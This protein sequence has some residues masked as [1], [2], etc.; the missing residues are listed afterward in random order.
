MPIKLIPSDGPFMALSLIDTSDIS[1][2]WLD[3]S[4]TPD[5]PHPARLLD[6]YLPE[7]GDGPFP[8]LVCIHG[9]AFWGGAK[10]DMQVAAYFDGLERGYAV[11]SVEQRLC[12]AQPGGTYSKEGLFPN[13]VNDF[14]AAIRFLRTHA[15]EYKLDPTRFVTAGGSAGGYHAIMAALTAN[16]PIMYDDSLGFAD[17]DDSVQA[18]IDWFGVGDL[19]VQSK[20][21][22][23]TPMKLP[24]G[25]EFKMDNY[26]DIFL[27]VSAQDSENLA[28]FASPESW[29]T[30][31]CPPV[32]LQ[33]G[34][35]D[36]IVPIECSRRLAKKIETICGKERLVYE[37]FEGY[38]HGDPRFN[39]T[40]NMDKIFAWLDI[41]L[42]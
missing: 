14:K 29:V 10:N 12:A 5:N 26:A 31:S 15:A 17:V 41:V 9:G 37:E 6:I 18:V 36:E 40:S 19:T 7:N 21:T 39:E 30:A 20:F 16:Q 42:K 25:T 8:T 28:K 3:V 2:K 4:Y 11:V 27:G 38:T 22:D 23:E 35:A 1:R 32:Y 33:H 13:P 34:I 24:D